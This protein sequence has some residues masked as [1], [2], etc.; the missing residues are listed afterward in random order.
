M[1]TRERPEKGGTMYL[2]Y[3][4]K[5]PPCQN[6]PS[7]VEEKLKTF[8]EI[9]ERELLTGR[10]ALQKPKGVCSSGRNERTLDSNLKTY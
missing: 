1:E 3:L 2:N 10:P 7:E 8:L 4:K 6:Y 9:K 5:K